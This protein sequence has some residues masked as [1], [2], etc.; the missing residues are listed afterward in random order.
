MGIAFNCILHDLS[1]E[2][3]SSHLV[4]KAARQ[5]KGSSLRSD[6]VAIGTND[7]HSFMCPYPRLIL[8]EMCFFPY[9]FKVFKQ[10]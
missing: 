5:P 9:F 1:A 6:K 10:F 4:K 3:T 7:A 8:I 2:L